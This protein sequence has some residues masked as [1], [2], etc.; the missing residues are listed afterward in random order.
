MRR[1]AL[2][3]GEPAGVGPELAVR[4]VADKSFA[5][6]CEFVLYGERS[7]LEEAFKRYAPQ[8]DIN[9]VKII[10][11]SNLLDF[12]K[13]KIG[14]ADGLCGRAAFEAIKA[15]AQSVIDGENDAIVTAPVNKYSV[16]LAGVDFSGHTEMIAEMCSCDEFAMMQSSGKLHVAFVTTHIPICEV[17]SSITLERILSVADM[18][19]EALKS[20][21]V[22]D[23]YLAVMALNPH[24]GE[25]GCMGREDEEITKVA[26]EILRQKGFRVDGPV[27]PDVLFVPGR[28]EKYDGI[29]SMYH[30]QGHIPF[31][32]LAFDSGVNSTIGL[33]IIR[34]SPDHGSAFDI[35]WGRGECGTGS[36]FAAVELAIKRAKRKE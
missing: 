32:M 13:M 8:V 30:D 11:S 34:C 28:Y 12:G 21:G 3:M 36:F 16:N 26:V 15:A 27:V 31:K 17:A 24:A 14:E 5:G 9:N 6:E 4:A 25:N 10:E 2:S 23:P 20:E 7:V 22:E 18:L 35:A 33:P 1:I 29:L 19:I